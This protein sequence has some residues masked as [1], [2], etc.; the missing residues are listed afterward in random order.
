MN[1]KS[2]TEIKLI[3]VL[4]MQLSLVLVNPVWRVELAGLEPVP[5]AADKA[6]YLIQ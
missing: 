6:H 5:F 1:K 4:L 2:P 3:K